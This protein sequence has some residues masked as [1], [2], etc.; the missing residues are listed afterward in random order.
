MDQKKKITDRNLGNAVRIKLP[1]LEFSSG[2][3]CKVKGDVGTFVVMS[4]HQ[5][6]TNSRNPMDL[7]SNNTTTRFVRK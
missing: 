2:P 4:Q 3:K 1:L 5:Q 7:K 6:V